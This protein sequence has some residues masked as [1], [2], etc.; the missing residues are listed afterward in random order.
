ML[1]DRI[2]DSDLFSVDAATGKA[3]LHLHAGQERMWDSNKRFVIVLAG[4]Q[5]GKT[6][7]GPWWL[8]REIQRTAN[9]NGNNDYLAVTATFPL[10]RLKMLPEFI[11]V[12][13]T[14]LKLG[15][16]YA[17]DR[18]F[19]LANPKTGELAK[20][21]TEPMWGRVIFGSAKNADS[22][23]SATAKAAWCDEAGQSNFHIDA[24]EA[25]LRRLSLHRG[26]ELITTCYDKQTEI[27]TDSGWKLIGNLADEDKV[28]AP[29]EKGFG[30]FEHP[31]RRT[32]EH[33]V[34]KMFYFRGGR[35]NLCV[36][37]N[38]RMLYKN[39]SRLY[40]NDAEHFSKLTHRSTTIPKL[41]HPQWPNREYL[42]LPSVIAGH[43]WR[44]IERPEIKISMLA[45]CAFLGWFLSEGSTKGSNGGKIR[46]G[47]YRV[48]ISQRKLEDMK[49]LENDLSAL[50]FKWS[51][52]KEG[53]STNNKQLW[54]YL[55][56]LGNSRQKFI[57]Q[58]IKHSGTDNLLILI[59]RMVR[60]DG[61]RSK[62]SGGFFYY[63][64]S[65]RLANDFREVC[66]LAG[67]S[68][69]M[70]RRES[71]PFQGTDGNHAP[72]Y[73]IW[74]R[75][76]KSGIV[77]HSEEIDY[78][79]Y[80]GC[81]GTSTGLVLV[82]RNG[83]ECIC[84]NTLYNRGW[85]KQTMYDP[86]QRGDRDDIDIIQFKSK[87]NP[88]FPIEEYMRAKRDLPPWK[89]SMFYEGEYARP[90]GM[91]YDSFDEENCVIPPIDIP[92]SWPL[93]VGIDFGGVH[94]AA[95][96]TAED[97]DTGNL[98]HFHEYLEGSKSIK[99]HAEAFKKVVGLRPLRWIGGGPPEEQW[100]E[101]FRQ[102]GIPLIP[103]PISEVEVGIARVY[104]YHRNNQIFVFKTL[105]KYLDEKGSYARI[106]DDTNEPTEDIEN[107]ND[108]HMMDAERVM[109]SSIFT[110]RNR[111][112]SSILPL[113]SQ[114]SLSR[115][116]SN[117]VSTV[118]ALN[119]GAYRES[120]WNRGRRW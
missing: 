55:R 73:H 40:I 92:A 86:W 112:D 12:F 1:P 47:Q 66:M 46:D 5:S 63:T 80:I 74:Q 20:R 33:Y 119:A 2:V 75:K 53:Y 94:M 99:Q 62:K 115:W 84:G 28:Y 10:L 51:K 44:K 104:S 38:H 78:N 102:Q 89:F 58:E 18:I 100:R 87:D 48:S 24:Q 111:I 114:V 108:Y 65:S 45:W 93:Y 107:K 8:W 97:P 120:R 6:S 96:F 88:M 11:R 59:D 118:N 22:L 17:A 83:E 60:G 52:G 81:V 61:T 32:W 4:A 9:P 3:Q 26:R 91:I 98:Y 105:K 67:I 27:Y 57:P 41:I 106:L 56:G 90:A 109:V 14:T 16:W 70:M 77:K 68:V 72:I 101:E 116:A 19:E 50:P 30:L 71:K 37:P 7:S 29:N 13:Q 110:L 49:L 95:L 36:T 31:Y 25:V 34:G 35:I 103:P 54:S 85:L 76:R 64:T 15:H 82:R 117:R 39:S 69:G 79:G 113:L 23:E 42:I 21:A 43:R